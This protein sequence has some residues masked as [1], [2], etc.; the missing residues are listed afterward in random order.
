MQATQNYF[1]MPNNIFSY[2]LTPI[3]FAVYSYL[4][5]CAGAKEMCWPSMQTIAANCNCSKNAARDAI[6]ELER[7][8]FV[9]RIAS[10]QTRNNGQSRQTSNRYVILPLPSPRRMAALR[11]DGTHSSRSV[12]RVPRH[13]SPR[14]RFCGHGWGN[15]TSDT[16]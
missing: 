5:S 13:C 12:E 3:Q 10:Y 16:T 4:V 11:T 9:R 7:R 8:G 15:H 6:R 14:V 2:H 1:Q